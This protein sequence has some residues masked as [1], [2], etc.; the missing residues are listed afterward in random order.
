MPKVSVIIPVYNVEKYLGECL[1]SILGQTLREIEVIC[2]DDASTDTSPKILADYASADSRVKLFSSPHVGAYRA[3]EVG[4]R[5][6]TGEYI[7]FMDSDDILAESAYSNLVAL[8]DREDLDQVVFCGTTFVDAGT[9]RSLK[10]WYRR[11]QNRY[12]STLPIDGVVMTGE[13]LMRTLMENRDFYVGLPLRLL[14]TR[15][16]KSC[17]WGSVDVSCHADMY[18]TPAYM[19]LSRRAAWVKDPYYR[20]RIREGSI[21]TTADSEAEHLRC[22]VIVLLELLK[23]PAFSGAVGNPDDVL[24][25][26]LELRV[27]FL[28]ERSPHLTKDDAV[29]VCRRAVPDLSPVARML[30]MAGVLPLLWRARCD[31]LSV[32][33]CLSYLVRQMV[34][35]FRC[36]E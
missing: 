16:V 7:H 11:F 15:V 35:P 31:R 22:L 33:R 12:S 19:C 6:A 4:V 23:I 3:R 2:V 18:F 13:R 24:N 29:A 21:T 34:K 25:R 28:L 17:A 8:A 32:R 27:R 36:H 30:L 1:D 5:A 14:R 10:S 20:R 9:D 26:Y